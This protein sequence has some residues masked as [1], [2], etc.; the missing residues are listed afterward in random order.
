MLWDSENSE[1]LVPKEEYTITMEQIKTSVYNLLCHFHML[2]I[3]NMEFQMSL[4]DTDFIF[5][6]IYSE[7]GYRTFDNGG[8]KRSTR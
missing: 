4:W 8:L 7:E 3:M 5:F 2:A 6:G 1:V